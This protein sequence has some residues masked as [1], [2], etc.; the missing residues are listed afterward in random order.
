MSEWRPTHNPWLVAFVVTSAAFMEIL[1]TTI[2]NVALPHIAGSLSSSQDEATWTLTS[3]LV[4]NGIVLPVSGWLSGMIGRRR[5][6][7]ICISAF[8][9]FS[10]LCGLATNLPELVIFRILQGLFGGGLQPSQQAIMLDVFPPAQRARAFSIVGVAAVVGPVLGPTLGGYLTDHFSWRWIFLVNLPVGVM[11][12]F[13]VTQVVE[14]PPWAKANPA[15]ARNI[16]FPGL[17]LITLGLGSLQVV[18]DRGEI[19]DWFA[20][21]FICV[22]AV[23]ALLG[24]AGAILWLLIARHPVVDLT[25]FRDRNYSLGCLLMFIFAGMLYGNSLL[26]PQLVQQRFGYTSDLAGLVLSP[27]SLLTAMLLPFVGKAMG[28]VQARY[29]VAFG[30]TTFGLGSLYSSTLSPDV[31]FFWLMRARIAVMMGIACLFAPI[32][33]STTSTLTPAQNSAG[34]SLFV[35]ARNLGGSVGIS[36]AAASV[37]Q[38][39]QIHMAYL[40]AHLSTLEQGFTQ[41]FAQ[42]THTLLGMGRTL[43]EAQGQAQVQI[44]QTLIRQ[45]SIMGYIDTFVYSGVLALMV[46]PLA[47]LMRRPGAGARPQP[48]AH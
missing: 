8:T 23:L 45:S 33:V 36:L 48:G 13:A 18:L 43:I 24:I 35:M 22:F 41:S 4:A 27:G 17:G 34:A 28:R 5:F 25:L 26:M 6:F 20:S 19:D 44:Y 29:L 10:V 16:D 15:R 31:G 3:Y 42:H 40:A 32:S 1:D 21:G 47:L 46:A 14:D 37:S 7:I 2:V 9:L 38:R 11:V 39:T 12:A 30:F